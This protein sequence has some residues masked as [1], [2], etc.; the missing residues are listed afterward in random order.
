MGEAEATVPTEEDITFPRKY[1][2]LD[3]PLL[4]PITWGPQGT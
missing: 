1:L 4:K 3:D 2:K